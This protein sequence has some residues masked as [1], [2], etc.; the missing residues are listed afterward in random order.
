[1]K[2]L[3]SNIFYYTATVGVKTLFIACCRLRAELD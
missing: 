2:M 3:L 1:M